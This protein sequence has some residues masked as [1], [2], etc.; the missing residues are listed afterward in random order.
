MAIR[1]PVNPQAAAVAKL[2][3]GAPSSQTPPPVKAPIPPAGFA[4]PAAPVSPPTAPPAMGVDIFD[5][6][7]EGFN[8]EATAA[9]S[10]SPTPPDDGDHICELA[11]SE[12]RQEG[13]YREISWEQRTKEGIVQRGAVSLSL[14]ATIVGEQDPFSGRRI[15]FD[16][17]SFGKKAVGV[18]GSTYDIALLLFALGEVPTGK[19]KSDCYRLRELIQGGYNKCILRTEWHAN[20][21]YDKDDP[22]SKQKSKRP[23]KVGQENFPRD[24]A[25]IPQP[26][27]ETPGGEPLKTIAVPVEFKRL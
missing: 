7:L 6:P 19:A 25:G 9:E 18:E 5:L 23:F 4:P 8:P 21:P 27:Y 22:K 17:N 13:P 20:F 10:F 15:F 24:E 11:L 2:K 12:S 3:F 14:V 26:L 16:V 1:P